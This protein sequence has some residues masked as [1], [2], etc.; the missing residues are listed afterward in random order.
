MLTEGALL[1]E[2][3]AR[4]IRQ[5]PGAA[6]PAAARTDLSALGRAGSATGAC[7]PGTG[8]PRRGRRG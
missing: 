8:W 2:R 4:A 7:R 3:A 1:F 6:R 5:P